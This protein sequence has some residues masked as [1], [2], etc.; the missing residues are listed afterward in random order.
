MIKVTF[1]ECAGVLVEIFLVKFPGP[2]GVPD[3][4]P[5][6]ALMESPAGSL[7]PTW[8]PCQI[9]WGRPPAT[10]NCTGV[11]GSPATKVTEVG[12]ICAEACDA[13]NNPSRATAP[14]KWIEGKRMDAVSVLRNWEVV[15]IGCFL[16]KAP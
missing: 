12:V 1:A 11:M 5:V 14:T 6:V 3:K 15:R 7:D 8:I 13:R 16:I 4:M 2:E 10:V 9:V